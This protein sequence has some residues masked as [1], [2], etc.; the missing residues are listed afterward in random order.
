MSW[1][2]K[3]D[4][5]FWNDLF[6]LETVVSSDFSNLSWVWRSLDLDL[7][8]LFEL[9]IGD[10]IIELRLRI[11]SARWCLLWKLDLL[12]SNNSCSKLLFSDVK[13]CIS[14]SFDFTTDVFTW[15]LVSESS[16]SSSSSSSSLDFKYKKTSIKKKL[17][18][19]KK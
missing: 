5:L 11:S 13:N 3:N 14:L 6:W 19:F 7:G 17:I 8:D 18:T 9:R 4:W 1:S 2:T 15:W 16:S 12:D 10:F